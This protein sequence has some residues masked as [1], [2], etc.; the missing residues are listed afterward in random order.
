VGGP[1]FVL[2]H[3]CTFKNLTGP[4]PSSLFLSV[5]DDTHIIGLAS[6]VFHIF[7]HFSSQ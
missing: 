6:V 1:L 3:F 7:R 4:F 2:A 5:V